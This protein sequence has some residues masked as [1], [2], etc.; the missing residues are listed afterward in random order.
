MKQN[1][2][3]NDAFLSEYKKMNRSVNGLEGAGEWPILK[4]MLPELEGKTVLD[5]GCGFGWH[6][7]YIREQGA[8][9]VIGIDSSV[10]CF[11]KHRK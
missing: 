1:K 5:L 10:K 3:D 2:Y 7:R 8:D 4:D 11:R 6:C 9:S